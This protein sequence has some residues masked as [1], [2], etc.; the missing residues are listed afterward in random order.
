M[1]I[2]IIKEQKVSF[3]KVELLF[4]HE[5]LHLHVVREFVPICITNLGVGGSRASSLW[6][7]CFLPKI[8]SITKPLKVN[9]TF[10]LNGN[11]KKRWKGIH[12]W[13]WHG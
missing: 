5:Y 3:Q 12:Y 6:I 1:Q 8:L 13:E 11:Q 4:T 9:L 7:V 10:I 2:L